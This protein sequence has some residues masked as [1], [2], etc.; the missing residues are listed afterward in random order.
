MSEEILKTRTIYDKNASLNYKTNNEKQRKNKVS[1][2][3]TLL[4][5]S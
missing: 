2:Q 3:Y 4:H 1:T 5:Y